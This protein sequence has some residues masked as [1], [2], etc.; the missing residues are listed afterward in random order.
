MRHTVVPPYLLVRIAGLDDPAFARAAQA[1]SRSL[2]QDVPFRRVRPGEPSPAHGAPTATAVPSPRN[3]VQSLQRTI[4]YARTSQTL[5]GAVV[6]REGE[7]ATGDAAADEA[8]DGLGA[9]STL[10]QEAYGRDSIDDAWLPLD[11]TVHYG[12][13]YDNAFWD[14]SRMVFGDGDGQVFRRF[15]VSQS[16]I[17]HELAHGI[18]E[19]TANLVYR[20]QSGALNESISD[21]FGALLEQFSSGH[22][23]GDASWLI[24]EGLF[25]D[26]VQGTALR[27]MIAPGSAYDDDVLGSDP[28]P[29]SMA[30]YVD[31]EDD[32][33]GVHINSGIPN[34]AFAVAA[35]TLGGPAW[36]RAG[37]VWYDVLTGGVLT[38][39]ADFD[40]FAAL[41]VAAAAKRYGPDSEVEAA[42]RIGW[43]T[44]GVGL[45]EAVLPE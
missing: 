26:E 35:T 42:V 1:A 22:S 8:Y 10:L 3:R 32:N 30:D 21:V 34:R 43:T 31:T 23:A 15:T 37:Q 5:P 16:V 13:E 19:Y 18:T 33:G 44:V 40:D 14:G 41:T 20:G 36:E 45:P 6:R 7:P 12:D 28:Q 29:G 17:G 9:M 2:E 11:A 25:T 4:A 38:A 27:S 24:G 39:T